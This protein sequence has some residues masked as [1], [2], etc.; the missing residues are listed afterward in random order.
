M[1]GG[2]STSSAPA[3]ALQGTT[4]QPGMR[5]A[6]IGG[7]YQLVGGFWSEMGVPPLSGGP[8]IYF[9]FVLR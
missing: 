6:L 2:G 4:G 3:H 7:G 9:W 1:D 5:P 8:E